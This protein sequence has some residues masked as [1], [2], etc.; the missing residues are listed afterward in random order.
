[1]PCN[2]QDHLLDGLGRE[3][4]PRPLVVLE[5]LVQGPLGGQVQ[6]Y[7]QGVDGN[8]HQGDNVRVL[9]VDEDIELLAGGGVSFAGVLGRVA[10]PLGLAQLVGSQGVFR[11][12]GTCRTVCQLLNL[13]GH[14]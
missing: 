3:L 6:H 12:I 10:L 1:M 7:G 4:V 2:L 14:F 8:A 13:A 9:E 11:R 5:P